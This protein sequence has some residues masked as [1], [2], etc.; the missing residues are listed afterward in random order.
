MVATPSRPVTIYIN[1]QFFLHR[2]KTG[3]QRVA[4]EVIL[5][6]DERLDQDAELRQRYRFRVVVPTSATVDIA[7]KLIEIRRFGRNQGSLWEQLDLALGSWDGFLINLCSGGPVIRRRQAVLIHDAVVFD[8]PE[9]FSPDYAAANRRLI[10]RIVNRSRRILTV[11][12]YSRERLLAATGAAPEKIVVVP[13]GVGRDFQPAGEPAVA[14]MRRHLSLDKPYFLCLGSLEPRKNFGRA[15][16]AWAGLTDLHASHDLVIAGGKD[17]IFQ[18]AGLTDLPPG[19]R[20]A[21]YVADQLL[22]ALYSG[23][24]ALVY[25]S[26]YEG[27]GLPP[28]EAMACGC[29]VLVSSVTAM[30]EVCGDAAIYCNPLDSAEIAA[31]MARLA[32]DEPLRQAL[33][34]R[35][36]RRAAAFRWDRTA[37]GL[38]EVID[39]CF[40]HRAKPEPREGETIALG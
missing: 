5:A 23:A 6:L 29:P 15:V 38:V 4:R 20:L 25:P 16:A 30:P 39:G 2:L 34:G 8:H 27:F 13:N 3:I 32:R 7:P 21:G 19:V 17:S 11:S 37:L 22:P 9:W 28:V 35:G 18:D 24:L 14:A 1:G 12:A 36:V 33:T 40:G 26:L 31:G 10:R